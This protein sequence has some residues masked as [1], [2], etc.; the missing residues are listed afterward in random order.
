MLD[1]MNLVILIAAG[2]VAVSVF[3]SLVSFR[4]GAP[5]L[6]V[7]LLVGLAAGEDGPGGIEF[8]DTRVAYFIGSIA[9][10]IILFDSGFETRFSTL[11]MAA[12][13]ALTLAT[14]GVLLTAGLIGTAAHF[15]LGWSWVE[16]LLLGSIVGS[17]DAA[18]VFFLLRVGGVHLREMISA[19][20]EVESGSN[21]PMAIFLTLT[22]V[23]ML[24]VG[25]SE[26]AAALTLFIEFA[27]QM[28]L[29][30]ILGLAGG[31][32]IVQIVNRLPLEPALY[33]I[34]VLALALV[35][36]A[37][38]S[39]VGGSGFLAVYVAGILCGNVRIR[40]EP[41][42]KRFQGGMTWL[43]Q[44]GMFV[45]LG[46]LATPSQFGDVA[47]AG[48]ALA[49]ILIFLARPV[50][51]WLCLLPFGFT[52]SETAFI[53]WVGLRGAVSIL[54]AILPLING[55]P[56]AQAIFNITFLI[57]LTSLVLQGWTIRPMAGW[58][59]LIVP[60][61]IGPVERMELELP[62]GADQEIV[63]YR[64]HPESAI[65]HGDRIPRWARPVLILREGRSL[66]VQAAGRPQAND[67]VYIL[68]S[69]RQ[70]PVLDQL[71]AAPSQAAHDPALFGDFPLDPE[72]A[73]SEIGAIYGFEVEA[74]DQGLTIREFM[75]RELADDIEPT[76]RVPY[77]NIDFVVRAIDAEHG[78]EQVG[79]AVEHIERAEPNLPFFFSREEIAGFT[80][81]SYRRL[82]NRRARIKVLK[83]R[84]ATAASA[85][86]IATDKADAEP[87]P[88]A[89][90]DPS[91]AAE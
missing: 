44:I 86:V 16:G 17:T 76:D 34:V 31:Y 83:R 30:L 21:D 54:L 6:L 69:A 85:E 20:L 87:K 28:G 4:V 91:K 74:E 50:A 90:A 19:T 59:K 78:I 2:L 5:L 15:L 8:A 73:L 77:G 13:P 36:F 56:N 18:A 55:L 63:A 14:I 43:G 67:L 81:R 47:V 24:A 68:T 7:F 60:P 80:R 27:R 33:P 32:V 72:A 62:G 89:G 25:L 35:V 79:L 53:S 37:A 3:T 75:T 40:Q 12:G 46:L 71:F 66:R 84:S 9:L 26:E 23:S 41:A 42:L 57:V 11:R 58:L 49:V 38:T 29:G 82:R 10:A 1:T 45:T 61:R 64:V 22:L 88:A 65:A 52:R 48:L 70:V 39:M 51:V